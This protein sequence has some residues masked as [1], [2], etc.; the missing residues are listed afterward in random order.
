MPLMNTDAKIFNTILTNGPQRNTCAPR[1]PGSINPQRPTHGNN[2][3]ANAKMKKGAGPV[4]EVPEGRE[5]MPQSGSRQ[6]SLVRDQTINISGL[7][8]R[9]F[10]RNNS[11]LLRR[12][13][14]HGAG[15]YMGVAECQ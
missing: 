6:T 12:E 7:A 10:C 11:S 14:V 15:K 1:A 3:N 8:G 9:A 4:P 13:Q 2:R 5:A